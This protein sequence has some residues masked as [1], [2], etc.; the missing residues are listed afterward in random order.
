MIYKTITGRKAQSAAS[1]AIAA[2][3]LL[4]AV[5]DLA[6][7][8]DAMK[9]ETIALPKP[10]LKGMISFEEAVTK[11]RSV[12]KY[13]DKVVT[14]QQ[15]SQLLWSA[16]G[17]TDMR[18]LRAAPSAGALYPLEIYVART[19]G[20]FKYR[21][22]GHKLVMMNGEDTRRDLVAASWGQ[23]FIAQAPINIIICAVYERVTSRYGDSG[24]RY[25]DIEVGHAAQNVLL[26]A[27]AL[28]LYSVPVGAFDEEKVSRIISVEEKETPVYILPIGHRQ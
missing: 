19:D 23:S 16:Q 10:I 9:R 2:A 11:R 7:G 21:P 22:Q 4:F 15:L 18:G 1:L 27:A 3:I 6:E 28:G 25:T 17:I 12:R 26:Q 13:S 20:L 8:Q 5:L 14:L 24:V